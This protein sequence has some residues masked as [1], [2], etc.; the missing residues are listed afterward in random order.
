MMAIAFSIPVIMMDASIIVTA[1]IA[2]ATPHIVHPSDN[3]S[4]LAPGR[5]A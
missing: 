2:I 5:R 1:T 4:M 3:S